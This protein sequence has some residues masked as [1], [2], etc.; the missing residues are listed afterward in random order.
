[1]LA[2]GLA[3]SVEAERDED[4]YR[5]DGDVDSEVAD[6]VHGTVRCMDFH[7]LSVSGGAEKPNA[8]RWAGRKGPPASAVEAE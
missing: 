8:R 2:V 7:G 6:A 5:D 4:P 3:R 1:M